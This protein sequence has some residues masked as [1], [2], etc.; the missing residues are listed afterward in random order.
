M[1]V[2][3]TIFVTIAILYAILILS[4]ALGWRRVPDFSC[5]RNIAAPSTTFAS[6]IIAVR[7]E[8]KNI[9]TCLN[10]LLKQDFQLSNFEIIVVDDHSID[11]TYSEVNEIVLKHSNVKLF[12]L[13]NLPQHASG[14]KAAV[15][16]GVGQAH[17]EL[18]I[19]TDADCRFS[20]DWL[21]CIVAY[22][23]QH[24]PV[25]I[26][27]P[28]AFIPQGS[29]IGNFMELEFISL[30]TAGA[31]ALGL[32]KPLMCN[33]ANQ[34]FRRNV[35][36]ELNAFEANSNMASG[37]DMF[38]M[39]GIRKKYGA[40]AI[41]FLKSVKA[42]VKTPAP[43]NLHEFLMQ[44]IRWGSKTRAYPDS[45][46]AVV[47]LVVFLNSMLLSGGVISLPFYSGLL[48]PV[49]T[50]W[51][52]KIA[53]DFLLLYRGCDLFDRRKLLFWFIPFQ[54]VYV[55]Y[56]TLVVFMSLFSGYRWKGRSHR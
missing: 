16:F 46:T 41:H 49:L 34:A 27:A 52:L 12:S 5:E 30:V 40:N 18:I 21:T 20:T 39:H 3:S 42:I 35:F 47:A 38:L 31:G 23:E 7:N 10:D 4:L 17:G 32:R 9:A 26:S 1:I 51:G 43:A 54:A 24:K 55:V 28:V 50:G 33:G 36:L 8:E 25:M 11:A 6:I 14:K 19:T 44:R 45:F 2:V 13:A 15:S 37:D 22:F 48:Y 56:I 29:I 53:S